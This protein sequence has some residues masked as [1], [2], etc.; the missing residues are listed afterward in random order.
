MEID[1]RKYLLNEIQKFTDDVKHSLRQKYEED[2]KEIR[3][4]AKKRMDAEEK[5]LND[6]F[7][8]KKKAVEK[9][10]HSASELRMKRARLEAYERV[11]A[12]VVE[13]MHSIVLDDTKHAIHHV[14]LQRLENCNTKNISRIW[15]PKGVTCKG[16][17]CTDSLRD[18]RVVAKVN[19]HENQEISLND[20]IEE[21]QQ[22]IKEVIDK[23][24]WSSSMR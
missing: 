4:Q 23:D 22:V 21:H 17:T 9:Q 18:A 20:L 14:L 16:K 5:E 10:E 2:L 12:K 11:Y 1:N 24:I 6:A 7:E 13:R 15:T 3:D 8:A 19:E